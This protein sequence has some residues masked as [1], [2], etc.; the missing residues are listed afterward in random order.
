MLLHLPQLLQRYIQYRRVGYG[1]LAALRF[2]W[3]VVA[4]PNRPQSIR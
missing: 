1:R 4:P 2:A 3:L